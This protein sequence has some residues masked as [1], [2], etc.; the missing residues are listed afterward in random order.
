MPWDLND[1][2]ASFKNFDPPLKKKAIDIANALLAEGY[3]DERAIPIAISQA[4]K[5]EA[6][7][8]DQ[9]KQAFKK[10]APPKKSD[11]HSEK[12][13]NKDLLD[14]D[15]MVYF[16]ADAWQV[17]TKGAKQASA[18]FDTKQAAA[19]RAHEIAANKQSKVVLYKKDGS[20]E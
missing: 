20:P 18:S 13:I 14:N 7:A 8:S 9:E 10:Q 17:K 2:P 12:K 3:P 1:Y 4:K 15:V 11:H 16:D 6:E 19:K 5:W